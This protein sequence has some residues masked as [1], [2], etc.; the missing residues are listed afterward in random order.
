MVVG[1]GPNGFEKRPVRARVGFEDADRR[2]VK[3]SETVAINLVHDIVIRG[4]KAGDKLP[5]EP[6][7]LQEYRVSRASLREALRL[8][9]VQGLITIRPGPGGGPVVGSVDARHLARTASLYFHL[10]GMRYA[11]IFATQ[12]ILEPICAQL[13]ARHPDRAQQMLPYLDTAATPNQGAAYHR[14]TLEFHHAVYELAGNGVLGLL[15][16]AITSIISSHI[17]ATMDPVELHDAIIEQHA[18]IARTISAGRDLKAQ[19][20]MADHFRAQHDYYQRNWPARFD[21][22]IEWR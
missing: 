8:L 6:A 18:E 12:E 17:T 14:I 11:D 21:E 3:T 2:V 4:L 22:L 13:A 16:N 15:T 19:Q 5:L 20:L 7:M 1:A 9:E 10:G